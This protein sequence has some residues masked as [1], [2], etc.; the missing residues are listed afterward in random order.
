MRRLLILKIFVFLFF[1]TVVIIH[2]PCLGHSGRS[3]DPTS[4]SSLECSFDSVSIASFMM[5]TW[6]TRWSLFWLVCQIPRCG[7]SGTPVH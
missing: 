7:L 4:A 3:F 1:R 6:W 2:L 5:N